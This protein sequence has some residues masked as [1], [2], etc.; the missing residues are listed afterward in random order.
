MNI[1]S[2]TNKIALKTVVLL[3]YWVFIFVCST[4][5]GFKVFREN[6]TEMF[7]LSI[8]GLFT[9]L[10]GAIILNIMFNL[11]ALAEGRSGE[12]Q[13]IPRKISKK[14]GIFFLCSLAVLFCLLYAGDRATSKKKESF[15]ISAASSLVKEQ[16][17]IVNRLAEYTFSRD[18]IAKS[19]QDLKIL[20]MVEEKFPEI[21]VIVIDTIDGKDFLLKFSR[22]S[23]VDKH[24][25]PEKSD[26]ILQ[27]S[28]EER[29]YLYSVFKKGVSAHRF[30]AADGN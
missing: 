8:L 27:T 9:V 23:G 10:V 30:S 22:Y 14:I 16:K 7:L 20:S 19:A 18:Y 28:T 12:A 21:K 25:K 2:I 13:R 6:I 17:S 4:V 5:F 29:K 15:M 24:K 3:I 26:S 1:V 11:T